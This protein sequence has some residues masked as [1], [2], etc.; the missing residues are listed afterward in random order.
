MINAEEMKSILDGNKPRLC[1]TQQKVI[2][3]ERIKVV[4]DA[5][6]I[7]STRQ[8][9]SISGVKKEFNKGMIIFNF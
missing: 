1:Q 7:Y 5:Q 2:K 9:G 6:N 8:W 3:E 4:M